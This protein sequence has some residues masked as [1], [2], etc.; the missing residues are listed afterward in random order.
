MF[1]VCVLFQSLVCRKQLFLLSSEQESTIVNTSWP[2][3]KQS[4]VR[5]KDAFVISKFI[6]WTQHK[7]HGC[8]KC[9]NTTKPAKVFLPHVSMWWTHVST[10]NLEYWRYLCC[11]IWF[12]I[13]DDNFWSTC[14]VHVL[15]LFV[16]LLP[17]LHSLSITQ[18]TRMSA[19]HFILYKHSSLFASLFEA[20]VDFS[21]TGPAFNAAS[22]VDYAGTLL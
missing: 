22:F 8:N 15:P 7:E 4:R 16:N 10:G 3:Y 1:S 11:L 20:W 18:R 2:H 19:Q 17:S 13:G 6:L 9:L 21:I 5:R 12:C 14:Y